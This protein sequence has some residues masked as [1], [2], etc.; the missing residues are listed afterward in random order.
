MTSVGNNLASS[1]GEPMKRLLQNITALPVIRIR[2]RTDKTGFVVQLSAGVKTNFAS[3]TRPNQNW[4][5]PSPQINRWVQAALFP[6]VKRS[7]PRGNHPSAP[8]VKVKNDFRHTSIYPYA[9]TPFTET[10]SLLL[11]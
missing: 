6:E 8:S 9:F 3:P 5:P 11:H 10:T 4:V 7:G 1:T 2:K